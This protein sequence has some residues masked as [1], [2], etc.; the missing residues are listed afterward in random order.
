M[1]YLILIY[2]NPRNWGHPTFARTSE[3]LAASPDERAELTAQFE[4]LLAEIAESGELVEG[5]P[6]A[7]PVNTRTVRVRDG[8]PVVVDGPFV[9]TKEHLA[10]YF[11]VDCDSLERA[12]GIAAR[13]PD[14]R[15]G[16][17]EVRPIM[18]VGQPAE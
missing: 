3:F 10:G 17:V 9:E 4:T 11:V 16:A 7:D 18:E 2:S 12:I 1:K 5:T 15:F 14:A 13:F 8:V 6:L